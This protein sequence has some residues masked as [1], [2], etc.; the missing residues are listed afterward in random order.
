MI[1]NLGLSGQPFS[2]PDI[3][4]FTGI[5]SDDLFAHW[6][7]VGALLPFSRT[8][9]GLRGDQEP[10]SFGPTAEAIA[11]QAV[12][13]RYRLLPYLYTVFR[14]AAETGLPVARPVFFADP[15][16]STL[17]HEDHAFLLGR[18]LLVVPQLTERPEHR[19]QLPRGTWRE[20][21]L[22]GE[23]PS[24]TPAL[25]RLRVRAGAVL[26]IGPGGTN[27]VEAAQGPITLVVALDEA[28]RAEGALYEDDGEGFGYRQG[29][30]LLTTFQAIRRDERIEVG[31]R[32][33]RGRR[34]PSGH[35]L[36]AEVLTD[37]GSLFA[38]SEPGEETVIL[39]LG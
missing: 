7:G 16:D 37:R 6:I 11:R 30:Y 35:E 4:G 17:R 15:T 5:P 23:D 39:H 13:R 9:N 28:G 2:G 31:V 19:F 27:T 12:A 10:W 26:P 25:P 38:A 8:H 18:D 21:T 34:T 20:L 29:D 36:R 1:L 22:V 33:R 24:E 32:D 14:E 3:G